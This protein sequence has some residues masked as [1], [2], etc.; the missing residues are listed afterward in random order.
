MSPQLQLLRDL[1]AAH[2]TMA[3]LAEALDWEGVAKEWQEGAEVQF[4][5]LQKAPLAGLPAAEQAEARQLIEEVLRLQASIS[6][7]AKPWMEQVA[8]L[9]ECFARHPLPSDPV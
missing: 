7:R 8:P 1:G 3:R 6:G 9:L 4:R 2:Q 5:A